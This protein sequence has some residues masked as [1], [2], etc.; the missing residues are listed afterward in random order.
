MMTK[1]ENETR[2]GPHIVVK[3]VVVWS[4]PLRLDCHSPVYRTAVLF[5]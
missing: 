5:G 2:P 1:T 4:R 3:I